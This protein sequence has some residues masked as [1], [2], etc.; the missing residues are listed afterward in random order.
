MESG[1][2]EEEEVRAEEEE[3]SEG[4]GGGGGG[5]GSGPGFGPGQGG[6]PGGGGPGGGGGGG[7][8]P[9]AAGAAAVAAAA[10]KKQEANKPNSAAIPAAPGAPGSTPGAPAPPKAPMGAVGGKDNTARGRQK[11]PL[12]WGKV[13]MN[14]VNQSFWP[15]LDE[16]NVRLDEEEIDELFGVDVVERF[17]I[18]A[19]EVKPEVLTHKRKHNVNILLA[20]LKMSAEDIK[21]VVRVPT[22]KE[23][24]AGTLQALLLVCPTQEEEMLLA[25]NQNIRAEVDRTDAFMMDLA[26]MK[27]LRGKILCALAA[28]TFNDEAVDVIRNMDTFAMMPVEVINSEK[29]ARV[30]EAIL[31][32]GNFLNSGT[33]R[34]GAHGFKLEALNMLSTVKDAKGNTLLDY[35]VYMIERDQPSLLPIDDMPTLGRCKELSLEAISEDVKALLDSVTNVSDQIKQIGDDETLAAFKAEMEVFAEE[36]IKVR[37]EIVSLEGLMRQK[38]QSMMQHFGERNKM[39]RGRQEDVLRMLREFCTDSENAVARAKERREEQRKKAARQEG[40]N[41]GNASAPPPPPPALATTEENGAA[42]E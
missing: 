10:R 6:G 14:L 20:N 8:A 30:L 17:Q 38:L 23:L 26:D 34:G 13:P 18:A 7:N 29:L 1:E 35:L 4:R 31:A 40:R 25:N 5:D 28:K 39:S 36:A 32:L 24:E 33:A 19:A 37:E 16:G 9:G 3:G 11:K 42:E 15:T 27:G 22:Y 2:E 12:H 41:A 21:D